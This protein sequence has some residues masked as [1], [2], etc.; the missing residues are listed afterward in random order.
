MAVHVS[1]TY[2]FWKYCVAR[3]ESRSIRA[4]P[5]Q[6]LLC[7]LF[8]HWAPDTDSL[9]ESSDRTKPNR[10]EWRCGR[11]AQNPGNGR[12]LFLSFCAAVVG[13]NECDGPIELLDGGGGDF[14]EN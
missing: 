9:L 13:L 11:S 2:Y 4:A 6:L 3:R 8:S 1:L 10:C 14:S 7:L 5:P 12:P